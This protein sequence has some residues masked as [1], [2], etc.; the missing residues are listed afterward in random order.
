MLCDTDVF[1]R[2]FVQERR[3]ETG[4][5]WQELLEGRTIAIAFQTEAELRIWPRLGGWKEKRTTKLLEKIESVARIPANERVLTA[6]VNLTVWSNENAAAMH[7]KVHVGD[8]WVAA[9]AMAYDLELAAIDG[10]YDGVAA[11]RLIKP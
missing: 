4:E 5:A 7:Q 1:S 9:T 11:L 3:D 8:R 6:F 10:I 2:V